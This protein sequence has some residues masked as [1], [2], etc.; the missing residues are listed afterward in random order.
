L[1][2]DNSNCGGCGNICPTGQ[3]CSQGICCSTGTTNCNGVCVNEQTDVNNCGGCGQ[4]C[5][6]NSCS[7]GICQPLI[8]ASHQT[9]PQGIATDG[10][11]I[12]W[13]DQG[14]CGT[15][16]AGVQVCTGTVN[17]IAVGA[18]SGT[19]PTVL[20]SDQ[21]NAFVIATDGKNLY[22]TDQGMFNTNTGT[23]NQIAIGA[24]SG[25][26][27]T[28]LANQ[29]A[30]GIATDGKN[31]YWINLN[32]GEGIVQIAVG[33]PPG[34]MPTFLAFDNAAAGIVSDGIN[35]YWT[36]DGS[37]T[38]DQIPAID[39]ACAGKQPLCFAFPP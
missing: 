18:P 31:V 13:T 30:T 38:V 16:D 33:A 39:G 3:S 9:Q 1:T 15:T 4:V 14:V 34:T 8:L 10:K 17:Q 2:S 7:N 25:T 23:I 28:I 32:G 20:A 29:N 19:L 35:V 36:D 26:Q 37:G 22:W 24:P 27:P 5:Q 21:V 12:Y 11:N 6:S